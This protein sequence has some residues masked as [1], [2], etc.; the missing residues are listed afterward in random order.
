MLLWRTPATS[1]VNDV[2]R[3]FKA[4]DAPPSS[5]EWEAHVRE[6]WGVGRSGR[7]CPCERRP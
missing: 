2:S 3:E 6:L 7:P 1:T 5:P 4:A